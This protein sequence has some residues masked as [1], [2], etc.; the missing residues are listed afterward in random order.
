M[1]FK[2]S[3]IFISYLIVLGNAVYF[4]MWGISL[5]F[6]ITAVL[7]VVSLVVTYVVSYSRGESSGKTTQCILS[8]SV[9][10]LTCLA[11]YSYLKLSG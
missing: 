1:R 10:V 11:I 8:G 3:W 9:L 4:L 5:T 6:L 7:G 2:F